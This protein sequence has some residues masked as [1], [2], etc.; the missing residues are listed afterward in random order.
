[1]DRRTF[2]AEQIINKLREAEVLLSQGDSGGEASRKIVVTEQTYYRWRREY[3]GMRVEQARR[4][5]RWCAIQL[6][7][8]V[9]REDFRW[10]C[11]GI[12]EIYVRVPRINISAAGLYSYQSVSSECPIPS[13]IRLHIELPV[14]SHS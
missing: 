13:I 5:S 4:L 10:A 3:G 2:T 6:I 11:T 14:Y 7:D 1:M 12:G 8:N 9:I